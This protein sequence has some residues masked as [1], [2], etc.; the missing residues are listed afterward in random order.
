MKWIKTF[1]PV[2]LVLAFFVPYP[3]YKKTAKSDTNPLGEVIEQMTLFDNL[4]IVSLLKESDD[5]TM[6][7]GLPP[8]PEFLTK[9]SAKKEAVITSKI[10]PPSPVKQVSL[11]PH[12]QVNVSSIISAGVIDSKLQGVLRN[13]GTIIINYAQKYNICPI[14]LTAI[15]M[16]ESGNGSSKFANDPNLNNVAGLMKEIEL[17]GKNKKTG[18]T[19]KYKKSVP[20]SYPSVNASIEFAAKL[21]GGAHYAGGKRDTIVEIQQEYCPIGANNDPKNLNKY[22]LGGVM[23]YMEQIWGKKI[24][25]RS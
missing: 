6:P 3:K 21:L 9:E 1:V 15:I 4:N 20:R 25:V 18:K 2:L 16:H 12:Y 13:K 10:I 7:P 23:G 14:F 11:T 17:T 8:L 5:Y 19:Y 22:W 24:I